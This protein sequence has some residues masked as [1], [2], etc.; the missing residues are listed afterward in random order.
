MNKLP[1]NSQALVG[2]E[3]IDRFWSHVDVCDENSCWLWRGSTKG[4]GYGQYRSDG[5]NLL[6]HRVAY[7]YAS[8]CDIPD[9]MVVRHSCDNPLCCNPSHLSIGTQRENMQEAGERGRMV[10]GVQHKLAKFSEEDV[11]EIR[12]LWAA[13]STQVEL[14]DLYGVN[15][16]TISMIVRGKNW[17]WL[18]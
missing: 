6:A 17:S 10:R 18:E 5:A 8:G 3:E 7:A 12:R 15:Q 16:S 9:G 13:G 4:R 11:L 2:G 1:T 14:A